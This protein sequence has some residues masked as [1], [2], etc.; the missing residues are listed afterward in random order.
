MSGTTLVLQKNLSHNVL[1]H[2]KLA[3]P[4]SGAGAAL[5]ERRLL[6]RRAGDAAAAQLRQQRERQPEQHGAP[7]V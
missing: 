7:D 3:H 2:L 5:E 1:A 4:A 6:V